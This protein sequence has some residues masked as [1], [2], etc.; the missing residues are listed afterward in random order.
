V[1]KLKKGDEKKT[2]AGSKYWMPPEMIKR[3]NYNAK[4]DIWSLGCL[5]FEMLQGFPPYN[6]FKPIKAMFRIATVGAPVLK[7]PDKWSSQLKDLLFTKMFIMN[8]E[9]RAGAPE[10]LEHPFLYKACKREK[11]VQAI[12]IVFLGNSLRMNGF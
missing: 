12:E 1:L 6:D 4:V 7:Q 11:L 3:E 9:L 5:C 10:I 2:M 8:P